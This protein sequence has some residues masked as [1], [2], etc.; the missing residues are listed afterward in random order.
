MSRLFVN[1]YNF[2]P[3]SM[4]LKKRNN[5]RLPSKDERDS[6]LTGKIRYSVETVTPLFIPNTS[7][8]RIFGVTARHQDQKEYHKSFD[9]FS[10]NDLSKCKNGVEQPY[11]D[12]VIPGSEMRGV[13]RSIYEAL[14]DSCLCA[15]D[16]NDIFSRRTPERY[17][18][19]LLKRNRNGTY[20]LKEAADY[21]CRD[22]D[23]FSV[24]Y[25][26][27]LLGIRDG[28]LVHYRFSNLN[29]NRKPYA[30]KIVD[31]VTDPQAHAGYIIKGQDGP[32]LPKPGNGA[33]CDDCPRITKEKCSK[34]NGK[35][36]YLLMKHN[37]HVFSEVE[38]RRGRESADSW[39][40]SDQNI[41][42][43][44]NVLEVYK[45]NGPDA[46]EEYRKTWKQFK[47]NELN[48]I[49]VYYSVLQTSD[50]KKEILLSPACITR[51]V[52][53]NT[54][55]SVLGNYYLPCRDS[56]H[57]CPACSLFGTVNKGLSRASSV[58]FSDLRAES[59]EDNKEYYGSL[60]TLD[61]L[62]QPKP[63]SMEFYLKKPDVILK[64]GDQLIA[65]TFDYYITVDQAGRPSIHFYTPDIAGRK[66]YWHSRKAAKRQKTLSEATEKEAEWSKTNPDQDKY[67]TKRNKT[68]RPVR[69]GITFWGE[70][71]YNQI[72]K[73]QLEQLLSVLNMS[74]SEQYGIKIGGAKPLGL[75]SVKLKVL[76][77]DYRKVFYDEDKWVYQNLDYN[78]EKIDISDVCDDHLRKVFDFG[79]VDENKYEVAYPFVDSV[80]DEG[81][82]W[83]GANR[84]AF[85]YKRETDYY[86][87]MKTD[88]SR[89]DMSQT[90]S[91]PGA[92]I[93][94][95]YREYME[96]LRPE[97]VVSG[98]GKASE[99]SWNEN[100]DAKGKV[101]T[102]YRGDCSYKEN[103]EYEGTVIGYN[104][105][106]KFAK[107]RIDNKGRTASF[108]DADHKYENQR[109]K[110]RYEGRNTSGFDQWKLVN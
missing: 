2:M 41:Q 56:G 57:L 101:R 83:F 22:S 97:L 105:S 79:A 89:L 39:A 1:P 88:Y 11:Y 40:I 45:K 74:K 95:P 102:G 46:Y 59:K 76:K 28:S 8:D 43:I 19:G 93:Q 31:I 35:K 90:T 72:T 13:I 75:G 4:N 71:Y 44:E 7:N 91:G 24:F 6:L 65:W 104:S 62:G 73:T 30:K 14:T 5:E 100:S 33:K 27:I 23:D 12:P 110:L 50:G 63:S 77:V 66:F 20:I 107:V 16:E 25:P 36:C 29:E 38:N 49:P 108:F 9:F 53:Q 52:Y 64:Q 58:R 10:Y 21:I 55:R 42:I 96:A 78:F 106:G 48:T 54:L 47:D 68:I 17:K 99:K 94:V 61:E 67:I 86:G 85:S 103:E 32:V 3:L 18:A 34:D 109:V 69:P 98:F 51:E 92:R 81:F 82:T 87:K 15:L 37:A 80:E 70:L 84:T 60:L 26:G